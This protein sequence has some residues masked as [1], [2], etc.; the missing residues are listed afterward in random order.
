[1]ASTTARIP[2]PSIISQGESGITATVVKSRSG[3]P[4]YI[5]CATLA[6]TSAT[7]GAH[8]DIS[9]HESIGRDTFWT[10]AHMAIYM[11]GVLAGVAFGYI[12]LATT[13]SKRSALADASVHIW[14]FRAPLGAFIASWGG[15]AMLTSAPFDNW[16]HGAYGLDVKIVSPPHILLFIGVYGVILGTLVLIAGYI[17][18][19]TGRSREIARW[20]FLY[21][22][23]IMLVMAMVM[24]M[25]YTERVFLHTSLPYV[26]VCTLTP[27][28]LAVGSRATGIR[29]AATFIA[30]FYTLFV[31]GLILILPLFA[32]EP[33]LGPVYQHVTHFIPPEFPL[34]LIVPAVALDLLWSRIKNWNAWKT[35]AVSA[36]LYV[37]LLLAVE[38]PFA[39]FLMSTASR[40]RFFGTIYFWYGLPPMS[41]MARNLFWP[42]D[43]AAEFWRG[44]ALA[45]LLCALAIRWGLSRGDW[46]RNIKR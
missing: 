31:I 34:L 15:I 46:M 44:I 1:M 16:W 11:C 38:W 8:W 29:F 32:A 17:N 24:L 12:I 30:G 20:L 36:V 14:G 19:S 21:G 4:W 41:Y 22:G 37:G 23:G 9:W 7:I 6:V 28:V 40:N 33:K 45:V 43:T 2:S 5:W 10:P 3:V 25:E 26:L 39:S 27:I 18:R 35:A 13:F 42:G